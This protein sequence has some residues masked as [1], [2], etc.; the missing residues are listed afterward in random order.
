VTRTMGGSRVGPSLL[1]L[2]LL[3][4]LAY[5]G[6]SV[7]DR[8]YQGSVLALEEQALRQEIVQLRLENLRLQDEVKA[9]RSDGQIETIA[10]EQ[11]GLVKP[12]DRPIVLVGPT[13]VPTPQAVARRDPPPPPEKSSWRKLLDALFSR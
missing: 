8:W 13:A 3:P 2:F 4:V 6:Y 7:A 9:A 11:L 10:R 1:A 5:V 12:G